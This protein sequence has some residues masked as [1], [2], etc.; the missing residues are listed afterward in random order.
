MEVRLG[1]LSLLKELTRKKGGQ[2]KTKFIPKKTITLD[3]NNLGQTP[4]GRLEGAKLEMARKT[5]SR[6]QEGLKDPPTS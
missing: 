3:P 5:F 1:T 4:G 2:N 6:L